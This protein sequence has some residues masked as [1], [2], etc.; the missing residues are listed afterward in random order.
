M[1]KIN[2]NKNASSSLE[3][4]VTF[5]ALLA[6]IQNDTIMRIINYETI[7]TER[8]LRSLIIQML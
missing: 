3:L 2:R 1:S 7:E 8:I 6:C 4:V 5:V